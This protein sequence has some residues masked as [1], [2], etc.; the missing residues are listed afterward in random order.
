MFS[1]PV[2]HE[3]QKKYRAQETGAQLH[4]S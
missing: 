4:K 1:H 3:L 2:L